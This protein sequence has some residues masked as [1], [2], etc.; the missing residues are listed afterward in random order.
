MNHLE[1]L[2]SLYKISLQKCSSSCM[3]ALM[4]GSVVLRSRV[5][6]HASETS[7]TSD[8]PPLYIL[9]KFIPRSYSISHICPTNPNKQ[10]TTNS[11]IF[12]NCQQTI[13]KQTTKIHLVQIFAQKNSTSVLSTRQ[14]LTSKSDVCAKIVRA[15]MRSLQ[16][17]RCPCFFC[18]LGTTERQ[19]GKCFSKFDIVDNVV[20]IGFWWL[21]IECICTYAV[22][23]DATQSPVQL[24]QN[25]SDVHIVVRV[26]ERVTLIAPCLVGSNA[27]RSSLALCIWGRLR[28]V[29]CAVLVTAFPNVLSRLRPSDRDR[30]H[31]CALTVRV[32]WSRWRHWLCF[33]K[34][35]YTTSVKIFCTGLQ[36]DRH[37]S[38]V[39]RLDSRS[40]MEIVVVS[41]EQIFVCFF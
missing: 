18:K 7:S 23:I 33:C 27:K 13:S 24:V 40:I 1:S 2:I 9:A 22:W 38:F 12:Q 34:L 20:L 31:N 6:R 8:T 28:T 36:C 5:C 15:E 32:T 3:A 37:F 17:Q 14:N 16:Q 25:W 19:V 41:I 26:S 4:F 35:S 10:Q 21:L 30:T 11:F 39:Y 29:L